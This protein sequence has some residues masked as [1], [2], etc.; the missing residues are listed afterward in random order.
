MQAPAW[1]SPN[2]G[3][4]MATGAGAL[5]VQLGGPARYHGEWEQRSVL[6]CGARPAASDIERG[7][8]LVARTQLLWCLVLTA[9]F[10]VKAAYV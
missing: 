9:I 7:Q 8:R 4:V 3:P 10:V 2:A 5:S 6:G 1:D